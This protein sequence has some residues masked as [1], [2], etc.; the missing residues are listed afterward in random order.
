M[1]LWRISDYADLDGNGGLVSSG[2]WHSLGS[3][4]VYLAENPASAL[5]E[6]LVHLEIDPDDVPRFYQLLAVDI[7]DDI[8]FDSIADGKLASGT[9][10]VMTAPHGLQAIAGSEKQR[11]ALL[12]VPSAVVPHTVNWLLNPVHPDAAKITIAQVVRAPFDRAAIPLMAR[13]AAG[14]P[15]A[16]ARARGAP[17][18]SRRPCGGSGPRR[19]RNS[20][21]A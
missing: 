10:V 20:A 7:A 2:R 12:R 21:P 11:T 4:I 8:A 3:R 17:G 16:A 19:C 5:L 6:R 14:T 9:G 15:P 1:R 13:P 18:G